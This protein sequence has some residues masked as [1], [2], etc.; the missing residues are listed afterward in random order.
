MLLGL[1]VMAFAPMVYLALGTWYSITR[2]LTDKA[3]VQ[4]MHAMNRASAVLA[5]IGYAAWQRYAC[6]FNLLS[7]FTSRLR[8]QFDVKHLP[9]PSICIALPPKRLVA[10]GLKLVQKVGR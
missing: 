10:K 9:G 6:W 2:P 5:M 7:W 3:I 4:V 8:V 1:L